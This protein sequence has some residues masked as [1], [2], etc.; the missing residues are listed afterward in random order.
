MYKSWKNFHRVVF[1]KDS[2][3]TSEFWRKLFVKCDVKLNFITTYYSFVEKQT[4]KWNQIVKNVFRCLLIKQYEKCWNN[5]FSNVELLLNTSTNAFSEI[6]LF[7]MLYDVLSKISLLKST[8]AKS[9]VDAKNFLKQR[10]R[11]RRNI[12]N[13]LKLYQTRMTMIFDV[14]HKSFR[15]EKKMFLKMTISKNLNITFLINHHYH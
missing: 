10:N 8:T 7:E 3:F 6:S 9:N 12:M 14:K 5:L 11:I 13:F 15:F 2:K 1:D 4:K